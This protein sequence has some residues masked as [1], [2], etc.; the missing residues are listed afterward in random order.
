VAQEAKD[1]YFADLEAFRTIVAE[2]NKTVQDLIY[3]GL[4]DIDPNYAQERKGSDPAL[5]P[6]EQAY[7]RTLMTEEQRR[8]FWESRR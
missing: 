5:T 6:E 8:A 4:G 3:F 2:E 7:Y 1:Q